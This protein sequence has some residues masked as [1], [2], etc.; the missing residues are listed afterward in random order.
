M[1]GEGFDTEAV[2][3]AQK[4]QREHERFRSD[5]RPMRAKLCSSGRS[6]SIIRALGGVVEVVL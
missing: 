6:E 2:E 3:R 4:S 1:K 5:T